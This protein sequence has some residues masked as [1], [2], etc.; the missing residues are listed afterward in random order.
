VQLLAYESLASDP[1]AT[2]ELVYTRAR[3]AW[4]PEQEAYIVHSTTVA[5]NPES[6][7]TTRRDSQTYYRA[8]VEKIDPDVRSAVDD[9]TGDSPLLQHFEPYYRG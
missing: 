2:A 9:I 1:A 5:S 6:P 7:I 4:S 3:G 8:W